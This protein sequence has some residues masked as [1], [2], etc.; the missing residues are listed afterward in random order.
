MFIR[1]FCLVLAGFAVMAGLL[2]LPGE[3][4]TGHVVGVESV[5]N[6]EN[7]GGQGWFGRP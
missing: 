5:V 7:L 4:D 1:R 3:G 6:Y 2:V